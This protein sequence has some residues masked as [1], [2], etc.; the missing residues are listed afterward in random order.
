MDMSV[1]GADALV[2]GLQQDAATQAAAG[3]TVQIIGILAGSDG[4]AVITRT[5]ACLQGV[6]AVHIL[7]HA[8]GQGVQLGSTRLDA[9]TLAS[10]AQQLTAW[11]S[12]LNSQADLLIYGCDL[13]STTE[14]RALVQDLALLTGADVAA[15]NDLTANAAHGGDWT[16]EYHTG[17]IESTSAVS[18]T[19]A[20]QWDGSLLVLPTGGQTAAHTATA[21][22]AEATTGARSVSMDGQGRFTAIWSTGTDVAYQRFKADGSADTMSGTVNNVYQVYGAAVAGNTAGQTAI[23]YFEYYP[24]VLGLILADAHVKLDV[25]DASGTRT[26]SITV[27]AANL[28]EGLLGNALTGNPQ[29]VPTVAMDAGGNTA[30]AWNIGNKVVLAWLDSAGTLLGSQV[31]DAGA[32]TSHVALALGPSGTVL[33]WTQGGDGV[34]AQFYNS[35]RAAQGSVVTVPGTATGVQSEATVAWDGNSRALMTWSSTQDGSS[36]IFGRWFSATGTA[37][38]AEFKLNTVTADAQSA[39][40][41]S[42]DASGR[43]V[44][45]WQSQG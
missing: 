40:S 27:A 33:S 22:T 5:L 6:D 1:D 20:A 31:I 38:G 14:G 41:L 34:V 8:D 23:A 21:G 25:F 45:A 37:L 44:V 7:S 30:V 35:A 43:A 32:V 4:L 29:I 36:D 24:G 3:R 18:A 12:A 10:H 2:Q 15:S 11:S 17:A 9:S 28:L 39:S 19:L 13:A 16:L 42:V 26:A